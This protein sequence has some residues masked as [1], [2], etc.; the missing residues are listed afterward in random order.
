MSTLA[1]TCIGCQVLVS[2]GWL[3]ASRGVPPSADARKARG[4]TVKKRNVLWWNRNRKW[5]LGSVMEANLTQ[6][7]PYVV[8]DSRWPRNAC[9]YGGADGILD[10]PIKPAWD[11]ILDSVP[12]ALGCRRAQRTDRIRQE[13]T[14]PKPN[15]TTLVDLG[16]QQAAS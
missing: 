11:T 16:R 10:P 9:F 8:R 3:I 4:G 5:Y 6:G 1:Y 2:P 12:D 14:P 13:S 15:D 7:E